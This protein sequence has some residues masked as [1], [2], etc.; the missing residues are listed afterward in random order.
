MCNAPLGNAMQSTAAP[1]GVGVF[2]PKTQ[3]ADA[4]QVTM[5][6]HAGNSEGHVRPFTR[7][8]PSPVAMDVRCHAPKRQL[9][10]REAA[11]VKN[12]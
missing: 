1:T 10:E 5:R 4:A 11:F 3:R 8:Q 9:C 2:T 12:G 6:V 7:V